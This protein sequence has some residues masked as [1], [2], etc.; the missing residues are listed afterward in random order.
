MSRRTLIGR[1]RPASHTL[2]RRSALGSTLSGFLASTAW[3]QGTSVDPIAQARRELAVATARRDDYDYAIAR[4]GL[5]STLHAFARSDEEWLEAQRIYSEDI[6]S[7]RIQRVKNANFLSAAFLAEMLLEEE[8]DNIARNHARILQLVQF[9]HDGLQSA[10]FLS[11]INSGLN[12]LLRLN[13]LEEALAWHR[14]GIAKIR[15]ASPD[16]ADHLSN[17]SA[18]HEVFCRYSAR[19]WARIGDPL[20]AIYWVEEARRRSLGAPT[21]FRHAFGNEKAALEGE[22][23]AALISLDAV[24]HLAT[25][26]EGS[27][28]VVTTRRSGR[29]AHQIIEV[30]SSANGVFDQEQQETLLWGGPYFRTRTRRFT[31]GYHGGFFANDGPSGSSTG[32]T[33]REG[34]TTISWWMAETFMEAAMIDRG[35]MRFPLGSRLG[36]VFPEDI[37]TLPINL[38][39]E[40]DEDLYIGNEFVLQVAPAAR[41]LNAERSGRKA[42]VDVV[43]LF[44]PTRDLPAADAEHEVLAGLGLPVDRIAPPTSARAFLDEV[45]RRRPECVYAATHGVFGGSS[46][47]GLVLAPSVSLTADDVLRYPG[48]LQNR[49]WVLSGCELGKSDLLQASQSSPTNLA[50]V[51]LGK[52]VGSVI[53]AHWKVTDDA[54]F[55]L[56]TRFMET[57][58]RERL[59]PAAALASA[60]VWL[61][62]SNADEVQEW[63]ISLMDNAPDAQWGQTEQILGNLSVWSGSDLPYAHPYFWGGFVCFGS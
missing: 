11:V 46:N 27:S 49:L 1:G 28:Y 42:T 20:T 34:L 33:F 10:A 2:T 19:L 24:L 41:Y 48:N 6:T 30:A 25:G 36:F 63:L 45:A 32:Q 37:A 3:A 52:G 31:G 43:G 21:P 23:A 8:R 59:A 17:G 12:I 14:E 60:Q 54:T 57:Y 13:R 7:P 15:N 50:N 44:N 38:T 5:A 51:L 61:K 16:K 18:G 62:R 55:L 35:D 9:A 22:L 29:L 40:P 53:A 56:M 39:G 58:S 4:T 26:P 47:A